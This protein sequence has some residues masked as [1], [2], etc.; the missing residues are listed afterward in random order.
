[1]AE[2]IQSVAI[3]WQI[4]QVAHRPF[5]LGLAGLVVFV[6]TLLLAPVAGVAGDRFDRRAIVA[7]AALVEV[8]ISLALIPL[9]G[10]HT[11][12]VLA[13]DLGILT[14]AGIARAFAFPAQS[15]LLPSIVPPE[16]YLCASAASSALFSLV[17]IGGPALG[18][19]LVA[20]GA[21][22]AYGTVAVLALLV[23]AAIATIPL[24]KRPARNDLPTL[25]DALEGFRFLRARP[26]IGGAI[27]LDLFAVFFGGATALLPVYA[28]SILRV[29]PF[30]YGV[31]RSA[32]SVG[33]TICAALLARRPIARH[34]GPRL[35]WSVAIFGGATVLFGVSRSLW[36]SALALAI[37]G[38]S[39]MVSMRIRD[40]LVA[41]GTP[42]ELRGRV[43]A[44][45]GVFIVASNELGE[46]E[47]GTLAAFAGPVA[48]VIAGGIATIVV[49]VLWTRLF[50]QLARA[51]EISPPSTE[52]A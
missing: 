30:G 11:N 39:D 44:I 47:S 35:L 51:D 6:P 29:G 33:G 38:A 3:A 50:P 36:L 20:A 12:A 52:T 10:G 26:V 22:I 41:L 5:D 1:M 24:L 49:V 32:V 42:D 7:A 16:L 8:A 15:A 21:A 48:A 4:Y 37:L 45:E 13:A 2:Q 25:R 23:E 19:A 40:A 43:T 9:A 46:F 14:L 17:R 18:G 28:A 27:T 34:V 31:L